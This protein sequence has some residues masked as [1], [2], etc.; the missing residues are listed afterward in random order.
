MDAFGGDFAPTSVIK[1]CCLIQKQFPKINIILS[2]NEKQIKQTASKI[3][4]SVSS[5]E[6]IDAKDYISPEEDP[7]KILKEKSD[8]SMAVG[9]KALNEDDV[10]AFLTAGSTGALAVGA[11]FFNRKI[12]KVKR[13]ALCPTV[14][15]YGGKFLLVDAGA[16]LQCRENVLFEFAIMGNI[17]AKKILKI[18]NPKIGLANVGAEPKKG[19]TAHQAAF[20]MLKN[21]EKIN[22]IGNIEARYIPLGVCDVVVADGLSGN[23]IL[24]T[25]EGTA[26]FLVKTLKDI[27]CSNFKT[28]LAAAILAKQHRILKQ[29]LDYKNYG[30]AIFLGM[31]KPIIKAH[32]NSNATTFKNAF[33]QTISCVEQKITSE[34]S[35]NMATLNK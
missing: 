13:A 32:G 24:K 17:Y 28:K 14:P 9:L 33:L 21:Y 11:C 8:S 6:I 29:K 10:D 35:Q 19:T 31:E 27:Y 16:N 7:S 12:N 15:S 22:F 26:K 23:M 20:E 5:F 2:G 34:I 4:I 25:M 3:G 1:G 18:D 30:G